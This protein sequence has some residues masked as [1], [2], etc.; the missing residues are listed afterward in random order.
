MALTLTLAQLRE[1]VGLA[2]DVP[3][4][5]SYLPNATVDRWI[6]QA[7]QEYTAL[8]AQYG[9]IDLKRS[10]LVGSTSTTPGTDGFPANE[11]L[12][13]PTDFG[14]LHALTYVSNGNRYELKRMAE[15]DRQTWWIDHVS[16]LGPPEFY[17]IVDATPS[18][19][20]RARVWPPMQSAYTFELVY[21]PTLPSTDT[22][23]TWEYLP[24]TEDLV[25]CRVAM[26]E[27]TRESIQEPA[28]FQALQM[29]YQSALEAMQRMSARNGG[30]TAMRNT[31]T[32]HN[33][34]R[35]GYP[36]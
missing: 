10:S 2:L 14:A 33:R 26:K 19:P 24:G 22:E 4:G 20:A 32:R 29:R 25:I 9:L 1:E 11:I 18:L 17:A 7:L 35:G 13:L 3:I 27:A 16:T 36:W 34:G 21:R 8:R 30:V 5:D 12:S 28:Q 15:S 6:N 31:R 23:D